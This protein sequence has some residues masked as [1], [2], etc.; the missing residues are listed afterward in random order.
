MLTRS[1]CT[2]DDDIRGVVASASAIAALP[3]RASAEAIGPSSS[4]GLPMASPTGLCAAD[5]S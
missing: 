3:C 5:K 1:S 4:L 2:T